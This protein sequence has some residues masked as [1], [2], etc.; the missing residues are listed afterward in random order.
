MEKL[1]S[2]SSDYWTKFVDCGAGNSQLPA[3]SAPN[4]PD[5]KDV[6]IFVFFFNSASLVLSISVIL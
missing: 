2:M 5:G 6:F 1:L 4:G 3:P